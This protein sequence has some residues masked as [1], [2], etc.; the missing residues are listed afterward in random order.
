MVCV[1][2]EL[3]G[4]ILA[5]LDGKILSGLLV[6]CLGWIFSFV[7]R[8]F[9]PICCIV[10]GAASVAEKRFFFKYITWSLSILERITHD[11]VGFV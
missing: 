1:D 5:A 7:G 10:P 6:G 8:G 2:T 4:R 11:S 3:A 9:A